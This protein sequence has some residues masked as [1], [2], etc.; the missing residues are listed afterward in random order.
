[1]LP[2]EQIS[3]TQIHLFQEYLTITFSPD[4]LYFCRVNV[5]RMCTMG[6]ILILNLESQKQQDIFHNRI[7]IP[8]IEKNVL[9][10]L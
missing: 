2:H 8:Q 1:M 9:L 4:S 6:S 5:L 7:E 10:F 3:Q